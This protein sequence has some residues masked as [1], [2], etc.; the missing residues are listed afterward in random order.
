M[1][2]DP[3]PEP[4]AC[5]AR[6]TAW[7][8]R[9]TRAE[10]DLDALAANVHLLRGLLPADAGLV[11]VVKANAY[12]HGAVPVAREALAAG[13]V[14]LAVATVGEGRELRAGGIT[15][16]ILL[17]GA[18]DPSEV[19]TALARG[20]TPTIG[21]V[22]LLAVVQEAAR[23]SPAVRPVP[24]QI[25]V[26]TGL[27]RYGVAIDEAVQIARQ[28]VADP[29]LDLDG[30]YTHFATADEADP[31]FVREQADAL[32]ACRA[33]FAAAGI[34]PRR[35]HRANSAAL[36][37]GI[38]GRGEWAR[39]GI[40]LYGI[41]PSAAVPMPGLR[42][43]MAVRSR[44][45]RVFPLR[46]GDSVGY[47]RTYVCTEPERAALIP[48]G[49]ADGYRR[50]LSNRAWVGLGGGQAAILGRV[51][52]DQI[53]VRV[54]AGVD[55]A[56]GAEVTV[57]GGEPEEAAPSATELAALAETV[58]YEVVTGIS[59]RVPRLFLRGGAVAEVGDG[60]AIPWSDRAPG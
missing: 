22:E 11:A 57:L 30:V 39:A 52:M 40:A 17:L 44:V 14:S 27:H 34:R 13:A 24:L 18:I 49:Y 32:A 56:V 36:L 29:Y 45:G 31:S 16:P 26:D 51:S 19:A 3:G 5:A 46:P 37:R 58:A 47:G 8:G 50:A 10:I 55:A 48:I 54:P 15:A 7:V 12:G 20:L 6:C 60:S 2:A 9:A 43:V 1:R 35:W 28:V 41:S 38:V 23:R 33:R 59:S 53:V 25:E 21:S 42:P 4:A